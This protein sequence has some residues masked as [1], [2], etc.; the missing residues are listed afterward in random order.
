[1][2]FTM[3]TNA[4]FRKQVDT[5]VSHFVS[6]LIKEDSTGESTGINV[7]PAG[8][9]E[10]HP[11]TGSPLNNIQSVEDNSYD[12]NMTKKD[13]RKTRENRRK[14]ISRIASRIY[15]SESLIYS[16]VRGVIPGG[17][18]LIRINDLCIEEELDIGDWNKFLVEKKRSDK[19]NENRKE[20][21]IHENVSF[22]HDKDVI[23]ESVPER[24]EALGII[25]Q[26]VIS[27]V[28]VIML[29]GGEGSGRTS[30][31]ESLM[32]EL[33]RREYTEEGILPI[34]MS[35]IISFAEGRWSRES[36]DEK[37]ERDIALHVVSAL[38]P[39]S[40][41]SDPIVQLQ[42][43][44]GSPANTRH[45]VLLL[46]NI[47]LLPGMG[48]F[49]HRLLEGTSQSLTVVCTASLPDQ[50]EMWHLMKRSSRT[51]MNLMLP[52][53]SPE[54]ARLVVL[55]E[56]G[57]S[58][59]DDVNKA[60]EQIVLNAKGEVWG[61]VGLRQLG[62]YLAHVGVENYVSEMTKAKAILNNSD[63]DESALIRWLLQQLSP[64][65]EVVLGVASLFASTFNKQ[66]LLQLCHV[67]R[68]KDSNIDR[69][70]KNDLEN[71]EDL[72]EKI[73]KSLKSLVGRGWIR[74]N[75]YRAYNVESKSEIDSINT[76][77]TL[78]N[79]SRYLIP[80]SLQDIYS[81]FIPEK[82]EESHIILF[83][84]KII[85]DEYP[86]NGFDAADKLYL[87]DDINEFGRAAQVQDNLSGENLRNEW[88]RISN[89][90]KTISPLL[91]RRSLFVYQ[92]ELLNR[93]I[94]HKYVE[95]MRKSYN[96]SSRKMTESVVEDN[97][98]ISKFLNMRSKLYWRIDN[99]NESS[100]DVKEAIKILEHMDKGLSKDVLE[101]ID[102]DHNACRLN[103]FIV[104]SFQW[105]SEIASIE[106]N[107]R[108]NTAVNFDEISEFYKEKREYLEK[109]NNISDDYDTYLF[110]ETYTYYWRGRV[111][112][113]EGNF[114]NAIRDFD[115]CLDIARKKSDLRLIVQSH[116][117]KARCY[118]A[119]AGQDYANFNPKM[120]DEA[121]RSIQY[122]KIDISRI[123][124]E[125][126][127]AQSEGL[128]AVLNL[129]KNKGEGREVER[130]IE[131]SALKLA[132]V[133]Y[134][135]WQ[136]IHYLE[137]ARICKCFGKEYQIYLDKF[138]T[139]W[140]SIAPAY[141]YDVDSIEK[142]ENIKP[143]D[144]YELAI[145]EI[146]SHLIKNK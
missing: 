9:S 100:N 89:V 140:N 81:K 121:E 119:M 84:D 98:N 14:A 64:C 146:Y 116:Q 107:K 104:S 7:N 37:V 35:R 94:K 99:F 65:E 144:K 90:V 2:R 22:I 15:A 133:N 75:V 6:V 106:Q 10:A 33:D 16:L 13:T 114:T 44:F 69:K 78:N 42:R 45:N 136:A 11:G 139:I 131:S 129:V 105:D 17:R 112:W 58:V 43:H 38:S 77:E 62:K 34:R 120:I 61:F 123:A 111:Y 46:D 79:N 72:D 93:V 25:K 130:A 20:K 91:D 127:L 126:S 117:W 56:L 68:V 80:R 109:N 128:V 67:L 101:R 36:A 143:E 3:N 86:K 47:P 95:T 138:N 52:S 85:Q 57:E 71:G 88:L 27:R 110:G 74:E 41:D 50:S 66:R 8:D 92:L 113:A 53:L 125:G 142:N 70:L 115:L 18:T 60:I 145:P 108:V 29:Y 73:E 40:L 96:K 26:N 97:I 21:K 30:M 51:Q 12:T 1:M 55:S 32:L 135:Y 54:S 48:T 103:L 137:A 82:G 87:L 141:R 19:L 122:A 31:L 59:D 28:P 102:I 83:S 63:A 124:D 132:S 39:Q 49:L 118:V 5:L 134:R 24:Q 76:T 4:E 23:A